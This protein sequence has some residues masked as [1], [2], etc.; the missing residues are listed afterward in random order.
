MIGRWYGQFSGFIQRFVLNQW[1]MIAIG[2]MPFK[3]PDSFQR[4]NRN[5]IPVH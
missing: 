4:P 2:N 1:L 3:K 5:H